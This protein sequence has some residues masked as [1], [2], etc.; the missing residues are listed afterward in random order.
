MTEKDGGLWRR[1]ASCS[2]R[3][4][5]TDRL[6]S[7]VVKASASGA[8]DPEFESRLRRDFSRSSH[9]SDIKIGTPVANLPG[10]CHC[11]VGNGTSQPGVSI[12]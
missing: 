5:P 10:A 7:L 8:E 3:T 2:G 4:P 11:R 6:A 12:L 1:A 9:T